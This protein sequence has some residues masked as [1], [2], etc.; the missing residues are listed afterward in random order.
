MPEPVT[1]AGMTPNQLLEINFGF[2][3]REQ[4]RS[5]GTTNGEIRKAIE[6]GS[7]VAIGKSIVAKPTTDPI[8]ARAVRMGTRLAC[9]SAALQRKLWAVDDGRLHVTPRTRH[10]HCSP[11]GLT[12][13]A[14]LHWTRNPADPVGDLVALES[15]V[16]ML[17]HVA[18]CQPLDYAVAVF[19]SAVRQAQIPIQELRQLAALHGG[20]FRQ[21]VALTSTQADSG[22]ESVTRVRRVWAGIH[23]REQVV[24]D[25]HPVDLLIG[26]R[27][28]IQLDGRQ[29]ITDAAQL[30]RDRA[31]DRRLVLMGY[32][33]LR[34]GYADVIFRWPEVLEVIGR[35]IAQRRHLW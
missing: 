28:I 5:I 10:S 30:A 13:P 14:V 2:V 8:A 34:F 32:T 18:K 20:R 31:Q 6:R 15:V 12:P 1:L 17:V 4:L 26:D 7:V 11:D 21:A 33:V 23:A 35:A 19:D 9:V 22:I 24:I 29:H 27:L 16:N 3:T 25:G